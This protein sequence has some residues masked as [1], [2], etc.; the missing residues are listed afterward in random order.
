MKASALFPLIAVFAVLVGLVFFRQSGEEQQ[1]IIEQAEF[2]PLVSSDLDVDSVNRL[3][4]YSGVAPTDRVIL[5][6]DGDRWRIASHWNALANRERPQQLLDAIKNLK[7]EY[8]ATANGEELADYDLSE[9]RG[10]HTV[11]FDG[12]DRNVIFHLVTGKSPKY[13]N[14]FMRAIDSDDVF[15]VDHNIRRDAYNYSL[16]WDDTPTS[17][18][19]VD[20]AVV[21]LP[22]DDFTKFELTM[23]DKKIVAELREKPAEATEAAS[24][25]GDAES[26]AVPATPATEWV[27]T[28][29]GRG[30]MAH[31]TPFS[32]LSRYLANLSSEGVTDPEKKSIWGLDNPAY[33]LTAHREN[34]EAVALTIGRPTVGNPAYAIRTD[35]NNESVYI[36]PD[37]IFQALF[38]AGGKFYDLPGLLLEENTIQSIEIDSFDGPIKL[39][40]VDDVWR[41]EEPVS[42]LKPNAASLARFERT[43]SSWQAVDYADSSVDV[44]FANS[45]QS[46][47]FG[48]D[49]ESHTIAL[50]TAAKH[51]AGRYARL[52]D[53]DEKLVMAQDDVDA[54]FMPYVD[55]FDTD[56][57]DVPIDEA[58]ESIEMSKA[59]DVNTFT[60]EDSAWIA[61]HSDDSFEAKVAE[62][63]SLIELIDTLETVGIQLPDARSEGAKVGGYVITTDQGTA[64]TIDVFEQV[65]GEYPVVVNGAQT[66]SLIN[67]RTFNKLFPD[68]E[69]FR[70][71][72]GESVTTLSPQQE[73]E[74][75]Q[76]QLQ[77][78][79]VQADPH[80]GHNH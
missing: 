60:L 23:P 44:G 43:L 11:G 59:S 78:A 55:L 45:A 32:D 4:I 46:V 53:S 35:N 24:D 39:A 71:K 62:I 64:W 41:I 49:L 57:V 5:E 12:P 38:A 80:A 14:M 30:G 19:W 3:E 13:G 42:D 29:G 52:D 54:V 66:A 33:Q 6:R 21:Q 1:T 72:E 56:M 50:G 76:Q 20:K 31:Q 36:I 25:E 63:D 26:S 65:D 68:L 40:K 8:R 22:G 27:V 37:N 15:L 34:G 77:T 70:P 9:D 48:N 73:F 17:P 10:W 16:D 69:T 75:L 18:A 28:Q 79:P 7:G 61:S 58:I 47:R 67:Q 74:Q 2:T 51:V